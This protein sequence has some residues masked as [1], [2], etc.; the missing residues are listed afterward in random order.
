MSKRIQWLVLVVVMAVGMAV[1]GCADSSGAVADGPATTD[2]DIDPKPCA[3]VYQFVIDEN[4]MVVP[5]SLPPEEV[6]FCIKNE[7]QS[8]SVFGFEGPTLPD[9][10][11]I[12]VPPGGHEMFME[13]T[14]KS[15]EHTFL[16]SDGWN[17]CASR[18]ANH[19]QRGIL[20]THSI[21]SYSTGLIT[22]IG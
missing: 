2:F 13:L 9:R 15:G 17:G 19:C 21:E 22:H 1:V 8:E 20:V 4:G 12:K 6:T 5:D 16:L 7:S 3:E 14:M 18:V 11:E 10:F